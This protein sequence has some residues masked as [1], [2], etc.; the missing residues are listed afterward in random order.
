[1]T[2]ENPLNVGIQQHSTT[3]AETTGS[4]DQ[5]PAQTTGQTLPS[6]NLAT[7]CLEI[8]ENYRWG[9]LAKSA[10]I[11]QLT[12]VVIGEVGSATSAANI[13]GTYFTMLDQYESESAHVPGAPEQGAPSGGDYWED[14]AEQEFAGED[15][16]EPNVEQEPNV[17]RGEPAR[18]RIKMDFTCFDHAAATGVV[19]KISKNLQ[20]TNEV[21][22]S[23]SQ[24]PREARRRLMY[25]QYSP[26]FHES[27]WNEIVRGK[28]L[29]LDTVYT[30]IAT[31]QT[32][33]K[34]TETIGGIEIKYGF[35]ETAS[36]KITSYQGWTTAWHRA[37]KAIRFAFPHREAELNSY[38]E[39]I[40][41]IF[42][43]TAE[44]HHGRVIRFDKAV[45]NRVASSRTYELSNFEAF[46]DI[47]D[48]IFLTT[49]KQYFDSDTPKSTSARTK[50]N[51]WRDPCLNWNNGKCTRSQNS[52]R[53][54]HVC[55]F[56]NQDGQWC[57]RSH[58][59]ARH[60]QPDSKPGPSRST[61]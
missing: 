14:D 35:A 22:E 58:T 11:V 37:S 5:P 9:L 59:E 4:G 27:G 6:Q 23:W 60:G 42:D 53:Y 10:A 51:D 34:H 61:N 32:V 13:V 8:V 18:K 7:A 28:C 20:R 12:Q 38:Y 1:M 24:D 39:Y 54:A 29:N 31:S 41:Q 17:E 21:L 15:G 50:S 25:H 3:F 55:S 30:F 19:C 33:D 2:K 43:Q 45:R 52:C 16:R 57:R 40:V 36:K 49:G 46:R 56:K 44:A 26:E 47:Y 48:A